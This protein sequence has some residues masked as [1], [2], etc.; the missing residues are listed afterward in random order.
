[1]KKIENCYIIDDDPISIFGTKM[2][3]KKSNHLFKITT[4]QNG[5]DG[6]RK[7][8][9]VLQNGQRLPSVIFLDLDMP[10]M[11]GWEFLDIFTKIEESKREHVILIVL[12]SSDHVND[13]SR[14]MEYKVVTAYLVKPLT[15]KNAGNFLKGF[16]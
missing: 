1:M 12:S 11:D 3:L 6:I 14:A 5:E 16:K 7:I 10:I 9:S 13:R 4:F 2:V 15:Q 8:K